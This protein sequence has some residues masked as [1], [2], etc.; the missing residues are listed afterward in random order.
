MV[1]RRVVPAQHTLPAQVTCV[2]L[3]D[4]RPPYGSS[5]GTGAGLFY[6]VLPAPP[7]HLSG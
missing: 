3:Q 5:P 6:L 2:E 4:I 7:T 1:F